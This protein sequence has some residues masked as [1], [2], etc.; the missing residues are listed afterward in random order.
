MRIWSEVWWYSLLM[1]LFLGLIGIYRRTNA[2]RIR[3]RLRKSN[4]HI[5]SRVRR[6]MIRF[7]VRPPRK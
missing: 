4:R 5:T 3:R 2:S 6:P 7:S 1:L